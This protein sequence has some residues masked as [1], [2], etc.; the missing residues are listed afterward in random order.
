M[1]AKVEIRHLNGLLLYL[2]LGK[3]KHQ[4]KESGRV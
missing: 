4:W 1:A 2:K 3:N